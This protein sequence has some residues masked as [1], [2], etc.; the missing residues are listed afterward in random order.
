M[1]ER[2][3]LRKQLN[4]TSST[5]NNKEMP[6]SLTRQRQDWWWAKQKKK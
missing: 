2:E 3:T 5:V 4:R 6:T 1:R